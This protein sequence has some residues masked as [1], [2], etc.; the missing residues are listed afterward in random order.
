LIIGVIALAILNIVLIPATLAKYKNI[1][2]RLPLFVFIMCSLILCFFIA[3]A[4]FVSDELGIGGDKA[5]P[6]YGHELIISAAIGIVFLLYQIINL[7]INKSR[8][9]L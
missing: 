9:G 4:G 8:H 6:L 2:Y 7:T 5:A 3:R 1:F